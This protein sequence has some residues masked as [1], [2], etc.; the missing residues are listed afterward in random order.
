MGRWCV[1]SP[2]SGI[3]WA[4]SGKGYDYD[5]IF[6]TFKNHCSFISVFRDSDKMDRYCFPVHCH[7]R[8]FIIV[9]VIVVL[10]DIVLSLSLKGIELSNMEHL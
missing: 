1:N 3:S 4:L 9:I 2:V 10:T 5:V 6:F 7:N 8:S